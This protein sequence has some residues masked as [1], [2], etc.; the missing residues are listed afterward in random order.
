MIKYSLSYILFYIYKC[1]CV[2][3]WGWQILFWYEAVSRHTLGGFLQT[4]LANRNDLGTGSDLCKAVGSMTSLPL[5]PRPPVCSTA[6]RN[7]NRSGRHTCPAA[8]PPTPPFRLHPCACVCVSRPSS[9]PLTTSHCN[10]HT[11][12]PPESLSLSFS[13][14]LS[15]SPPPS[16]YFWSRQRILMSLTMINLINN[17]YI[18]LASWQGLILSSGKA[19]APVNCCL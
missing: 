11:Q 1:V 14:C 6:L 3:V 13:S 7:K 10:H 4:F 19:Q 18:N 9:V 17:K 5:P 2:C 12:L 16:T 8:P 15:F